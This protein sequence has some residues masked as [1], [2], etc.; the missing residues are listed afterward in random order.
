M[1][2]N[3]MFSVIEDILKRMLT[4]KKKHPFLTSLKSFATALHFYYPKA[5]D[6]VRATFLN[7]LPHPSTIRQ[8]YQCVDGFPGICSEALLTSRFKAQKAKETG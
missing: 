6:Y 3:S 4:E 8:W 2:Q 5:Y 7:S 1:F